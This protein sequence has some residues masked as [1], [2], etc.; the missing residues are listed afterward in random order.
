M[1]IGVSK[2]APMTHS[3]LTATLLV[4]P[5]GTGPL[6]IPTPTRTRTTAG[7]TTTSTTAGPPTTSST[8]L[9]SIPTDTPTGTTSSTST[10][11]ASPAGKDN[12]QPQLTSGQIAGISLGV[13]AVVILG[14]LLIFLARYI[15]KKRYPDL[16]A[17][18]GFAKIDD[19]GTAG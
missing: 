7:T 1:C 8:T 19:S 18:S 16:E 15:R 6:I 13:A 5:T 9:S 10:A 11:T 17:A 2:A 4:P 14:V 3:T 12:D